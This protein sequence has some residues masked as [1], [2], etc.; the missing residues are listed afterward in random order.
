MPNDFF[1]LG[2]GG[3]KSWSHTKITE[4]AITGLYQEFFG[5]TSVDR[6]G[7]AAIANISD[8]NARVDLGDEFDF[9]APHFT[10]ENFNGAQQRLTSFKSKV[11]SMMQGAPSNR[12]ISQAQILLGRALHTLQDFYAHSNWVERNPSAPSTQV[13]PTIGVVGQPLNRPPRGTKTCQFCE[14]NNCDQCDNILVQNAILTTGYYGG[15]DGRSG[16]PNGKCAHG[17][18]VSVRRDSAGDGSISSGINKDTTNCEISPREDL[19]DKARNFAI[20]ATKKYLR[21]I[22][23]SIGSVFTAALLAGNTQLA[24]VVDTTGSM[25]PEIAS[26]RQQIFQIIN[27]R[28]SLGIPTTYI[29]VPYNDP[30]IGTVT[31]TDDP[32]VFTTAVNALDAF[33][34]GDCPEPLNKAL[35][36]A[37]SEIQSGGD[38]FLFTDARAKDSDLTFSV[39]TF[40]R[41]SGI[42]LTSVFSGEFDCPLLDGSLSTLSFDTGGQFFSLGESESGMLANLGNF[43]AVPNQ[44]ELFS[45]LGTIGAVAQNFTIPV[46]SF[47]NRMILSVSGTGATNI[48]VRRP[49]NTIVQA[50]DPN[51]SQI[52]LS[53]GT[54][55]SILNPAVGTWTISIAGTSGFGM[56]QSPDL[57]YITDANEL[58]FGEPESGPSNRFEAIAPLAAA[59]A[60]A[61]PQSGQQFS[62]RVAGES[63]I[64]VTSFEFMEFADFGAHPGYRRIVGSPVP[65]RL[66]PVALTLAAAGA[67]T[68]VVQFRGLDGSVL[69]TLNL[70][71]VGWSD[72]PSEVRATGWKIYFGQVVIPSVP[73][74]VYVT[75]QTTNGNA[76]QR[77]LPGVIRPQTVE[78]SAPPIANLQPGQSMTYNMQVKNSGPADTFQLTA[79][80]DENYLGGISPASFTLGTNETKNIKVQIKVPSNAVPLT[81]DTLRFTVQGTNVFNT[82]IVG[83]LMVDP[84]AALA[85]GTV[86]ATAIGGDGD[87]FIEPGEGAS[88]SFQLINNGSN[89]ASNIIAG[90]SSSTTGV[91]VSQ[92]SS[93]YADIGPGASG[94]NLSPFIVYLPPNFSCGQTVDLRLRVSSE[95]N[96]VSEG[97]YH[98]SIPTGQAVSSSTLTRSFTGPAVSIPD[99][100]AAGVDVPVTVS[101]FTG[102]ITDLNFRIDGTNCSTTAG[103]T[104]VG[105][106]HTAAS[107]LILKLKSPSGA[108]INLITGTGG[109]GNNFCQTTLDDETSGASI[110][111]L[112]STNAPF[113]GTFKPD[114]SLSLFRGES[115]NGIWTLNVSDT[116]LSNSG[117]VRAFSL[118]FSGTQ[119]SCNAA[120]ADTTAPSCTSTGSASLTTQDTG[121]GLA[122]IHVT[123]AEN[124]NVT[125]PTFTP[126]TTAPVVVTGTL[127][128]PN[129]NGFFEIE[130]VDVAGNVSNC[131]R[132]I[133]GASSAS[134]ILSDDF[135]DNNLNSGPLTINGDYWRTDTLLTIFTTNFNLPV[136][137]TAQH[138]EIGPLLVNTADAYGGVA[139]AL[140]YTFPAG[141]Y[142]YVEL[143]QAPSAQT[144]ADAGFAFGN[145]V[146]YYQIRVSHGSLIGVKNIVSNETILFSIPYDPVAHRFLRIRHVSASGNVVFDT[147]PGNGGVPGTWTQRYSEP[148]NSTLGFNS[149]QF[150]MRGGTL[151]AEPNQ[152]GK[153][154]FDNFQFG[155][156]SP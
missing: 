149:F 88:L 96:T 22:R 74:H 73:F 150:E 135:N 78:I 120:P 31:V 17:G 112:T 143:G 84:I 44:T 70:Q 103:S 27:T 118:L 132:T 18:K 41:T 40:A 37:F 68:A 81:L 63:T 53:S 5:N 119:Y 6:R 154:I 130:S 146:G 115:A 13:H 9:S 80:D 25:G 108:S 123:A 89:T 52:S 142:S 72:D 57:D 151:V 46:D 128:D 92:N 87:A 126:G 59:V 60:A 101:G 24:F 2:F 36:R 129:M 144:H 121:T 122:T 8:A 62:I 47:L 117:T 21:E 137:E 75:G 10:S 138:L 133:T 124:V 26:V 3:P 93:D 97:Q 90:L 58:N 19:H 107:D 30:A 153:V 106:S 23:N 152:P 155:T 140:Q 49:D 69:Q 79:V 7:R 50:T 147:A 109:D 71:D 145:F 131:N 20:E 85:L 56:N 39:G 14:R 156:L 16:K 38:M 34:G 15:D 102:Q 125:V 83:P 61:P 77:V 114:D 110:Q 98:V 134:I 94:T 35:L 113:T 64:D 66:T 51:V 148:W 76:Y 116:A 11:I 139:T 4:G 95:G 136:A 48:V 65:G 33:G 42:R 28:I 32:N 111:T 82:A 86:T 29:L 43:L 55:Y 105:I 54:F 45:R 104:T 100:I 67:S 91:V 12:T 127:I 141:G 99:N 1:A